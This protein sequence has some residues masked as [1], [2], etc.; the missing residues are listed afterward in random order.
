[1]KIKLNIVLLN[2]LFFSIAI[3]IFVRLKST[4]AI[5]EIPQSDIVISENDTNDLINRICQNTIK[6]DGEAEFIVT[7][8]G[9]LFHDCSQITVVLYKQDSG[10]EI[11]SEQV[12]LNNMTSLQ[13]KIKEKG[14]YLFYAFMEDEENPIDLSEYVMVYESQNQD[15][16]SGI[17]LLE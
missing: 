9:E 12:S 7:L 2:V 1:M 4:T 16:Q 11:F 3:T 15:E 13:Y 6:I 17:I 10:R 14:L 8:P 5:K